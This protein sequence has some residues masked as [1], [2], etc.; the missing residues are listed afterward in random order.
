MHTATMPARHTIHSPPPQNKKELL[1]LTLL[2]KTELNLP[3]KKAG[4]GTA[5]IQKARTFEQAL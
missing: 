2:E 1:N 5:R 3:G 4:A